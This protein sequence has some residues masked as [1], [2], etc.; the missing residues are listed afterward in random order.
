MREGLGRCV[1]KFASLLH[2]VVRK[3]VVKNEVVLPAEIADHGD[4][5]GVASDAHQSA[6]RVFPFRYFLLEFFVDFLLARQETASAGTRAVFVDCGLRC[7]IDF[8]AAAHTHI[9]VAA[10][11]QHLLAVNH[12]G[13]AQRRFVADE[14]RVVAVFHQFFHPFFKVPVFF[15][16]LKSGYGGSLHH[17]LFDAGY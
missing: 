15:G 14:I 17:L 7:V 5:C 13:V 9:V 3:G 8:L 4:V 1:G 12:A 11:I 16:I 6:F 10:E 2:G